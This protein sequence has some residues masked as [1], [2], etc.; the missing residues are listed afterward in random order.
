MKRVNFFIL[1]FLLF[2]CLLHAQEGESPLPFPL[3]PVLAEA[4]YGDGR[5]RP[6]WPLEIAPD[7]FAVRGAAAVTVELGALWE[8]GEDSAGAESRELPA[9]GSR[10]RGI[11]YHLTRNPGGRPAAFPMPLAEGGTLVFAQVEVRYGGEDGIEE[12]RIL[13]PPGEEPAGQETDAEMPPWTVLFPAPWLPGTPPAGEPVKVQRGE[14]LYYVFFSGNRDL[15]AETWY[16]PPGNFAA[17]FETRIGGEG[18]R[19]IGLEGRNYRGEYSYESGGNLSEYSGDQGLFS[20]IYGAQGRPLYW[21]A[22]RE[23][24]LQWDE[25]GRLRGMRDLAPQG[26]GEG[27]AAFRYEY[28]FDS[29]GNW[30]RRREI[31]LF[32]RENLLL[33]GRMQET[34]R[35]I[36]YAEGD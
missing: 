18:R 11:P 14:D 20:A 5:W 25:E 12:L 7:A 35:Q 3:G 30:V 26:P 10:Y 19:V 36:D 32:L 16:D 23:Y 8:T 31:A 6:D 29:R 24:G 13:I 17:Y 4:V 27:P 15:I 21:T 9:Q 34:V 2:S 28:E 1:I 33:P 22:G